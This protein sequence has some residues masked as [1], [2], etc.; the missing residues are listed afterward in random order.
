MPPLVMFVYCV[1]PARA[2]HERWF[3]AEQK[4]V[5]NPIWM[6]CIP[7][8]DC[9]R[10]FIIRFLEVFYVESLVYILIERSNSISITERTSELNFYI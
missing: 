2:V 3:A 10:Y 6:S 9:K 5:Q 1:R 7:M 8:H 4:S